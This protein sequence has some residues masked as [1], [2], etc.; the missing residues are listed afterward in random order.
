MLFSLLGLISS[1]T[2][3]DCTNIYIYTIESP[4][5]HELADGKQ[6]CF[7]KSIIIGGNTSYT[8]KYAYK[9]KYK[10]VLAVLGYYEVNDT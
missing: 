3:K 6:T 7:S 9:T 2:F 1:L 4:W 5:T 8:V 10:D